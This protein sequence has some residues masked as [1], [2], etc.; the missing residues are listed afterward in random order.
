MS[1]SPVDLT[2]T[3]SVEVEVARLVDVD[4]IDDQQGTEELEAVAEDD[5]AR[6]ADE[7]DDNTFQA[8]SPIEVAA[9]EIGHLVWRSNEDADEDG[10]VVA[11]LVCGRSV[12]LG[13]SKQKCQVV[14]HGPAISRQHARVDVGGDGRVY[15]L[16]LEGAKVTLNGNQKLFQQS[17]PVLVNHCDVFHIGSNVFEAMFHGWNEAMAS[18]AESHQHPDHP[19]SPVRLGVN[20]IDHLHKPKARKAANEDRSGSV[21]D[22]VL[23]SAA[24]ITESSI[25][26][27]MDSQSSARETS[28]LQR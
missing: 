2:P 26:A 28:V 3:S 24:D 27:T 4:E 21:A 6:Q 14:L 15:L 8:I 7:D 17:G 13:R 22:K 23:A 25:R 18:S 12:T 5:A 11:T 19:G 1:F 20:P 9:G 16:A 10:E